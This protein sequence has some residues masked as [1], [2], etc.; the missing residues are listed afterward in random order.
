MNPNRKTLGQSIIPAAKCVTNISVG[1]ILFHIA[2]SPFATSLSGV[3]LKRINANKQRYQQH[4][5]DFCLDLAGPR[6]V[7]KH[8]NC[9]FFIRGKGTA[10][11][12]ALHHSAELK[13]SMKVI[14]A[15]GQ[16]VAVPC[17]LQLKNCSPL[18]VESRGQQ[19]EERTPGFEGAVMPFSL[20]QVHLKSWGTSI[21]I[22]WTRCII[23]PRGRASCLP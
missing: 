17:Q 7:L 11:S 6:R 10:F 5:S 21:F 3:F 12:T 22:R 4:F 13:A 23:P 2:G 1:W 18:N 8:I 19:R 20:S 14:K 15:A 9:L 16:D